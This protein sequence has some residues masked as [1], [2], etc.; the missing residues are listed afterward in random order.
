MTQVVL[1]ISRVGFGGIPGLI[2]GSYSRAAVKAP[3]REI[4]VLGIILCVLQIADGILT[5]IG[6]NAFGVAAE[7]NSFLRFLMEQLGYIPALTLTK[8]VAVVVTTILCTLSS[9][10]S[11]IRHALKAVIGVYLLAAV[12]P[13]TLIL[14]SEAI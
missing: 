12:V 14:L 2:S 1:N 11:W 4:V 13:W 8:G 6:I 5:G 7:G 9:N 10:V 3:S